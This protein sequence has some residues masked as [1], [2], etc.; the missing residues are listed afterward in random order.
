MTSSRRLGMDSHRQSLASQSAGAQLAQ[1]ASLAFVVSVGPC[2][3]RGSTRTHHCGRRADKCYQHGRCSGRTE[4]QDDRHKSKPSRTGLGLGLC[5]HGDGF[6]VRN[7]E[8]RSVA[9]RLV[10]GAWVLTQKAICIA[11]SGP[12]SSRSLARVSTRM[13]AESDSFS[14][15]GR[16]REEKREEKQIDDLDLVLSV[17]ELMAADA[18]ADEVHLNLQRLCSETSLDQKLVKQ[19]AVVLDV[20]GVEW[21]SA[22][23]MSD[24]GVVQFAESDPRALQDKAT[25]LPL[26]IWRYSGTHK[27]FMKYTRELRQLPNLEDVCKVASMTCIEDLEKVFSQNREKRAAGFRV[28]VS[29]AKESS[30]DVKHLVERVQV[31]STLSFKGLS[32][33][34]LSNASCVDINVLLGELESSLGADMHPSSLCVEIPVDF[35]GLDWDSFVARYGN[36]LR[37]YARFPGNLA[38][39]V[40]TSSI[41]EMLEAKFE[42]ELDFELDNAEENGSDFDDSDLDFSDSE[43]DE[44]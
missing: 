18:V 27:M 22:Q 41:L 42:D 20:S 2:G 36:L 9:R 11:S 35:V 31:S 1:Y 3:S 40:R 39:R 5:T 43:S 34:A 26:S 4:T 15:F 24:R 8:V 30:E 32:C 38:F 13:R 25:M 33:A 7:R 23:V 12:N 10:P 21:I 28:F 37:R 44:E 6:R 14:G 17:R 16:K 19:F 29:A